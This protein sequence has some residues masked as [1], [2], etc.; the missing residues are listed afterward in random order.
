MLAHPGH[1]GGLLRRLDAD[2]EVH[3]RRPARA[4]G[5]R[6]QA[7]GRRQEPRGRAARRGSRL[8]RRCDDRRRLRLGGRALHGGIGG[9]RRRRRGRCHR[10]RLAARARG[11]AV[12]SGRPRRSRTWGRSS[13]ARHASASSV[14]SMAAWPR[15]RRSSS[16]A[17][18]TCAGHDGGFFV[19]PTLFDRATPADDDLPRGDLRTGA[20]DRARRFAGRRRSHW[21]TPIPMPTARR[22]S[23]ARATRPAASRRRSRSDGRH[24]RADPGADGVL[25]VRRLA[26]LAVRRPARARHGRRA[27]LHARQGGHRRWPDDGSAAPGFHMPTLG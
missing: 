7:L 1:Q 5:K 24:Q 17:A 2:R 6:V 12:G 18:P 21:S 3:L 4:H 22:C 19:G 8:R 9:G 26:Q 27:F 10:D 11:I 16:T 13:P 23:R 14:S 15:A 20:R 25:L